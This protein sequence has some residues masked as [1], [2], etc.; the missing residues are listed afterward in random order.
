MAI[1]IISREKWEM[2]KG[3]LEEYKKLGGKVFE[4]TN[5]EVERFPKFIAI[6]DK[7]VEKVKK[8]VKLRKIEKQIKEIAK[9]TAKIK[10]EVNKKKK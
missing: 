3:S 5:E 1:A 10:K 8:E 4:G 2:A 9:K 6:L 7:V